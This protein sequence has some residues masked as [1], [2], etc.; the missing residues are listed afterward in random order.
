L[1]LKQL[2]VVVLGGGLSGLTA[3]LKLRN[4]DL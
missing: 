3:A 2:D 1:A 4:L